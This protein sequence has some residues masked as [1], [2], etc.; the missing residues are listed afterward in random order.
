MARALSVAD[1]ERFN[2][3]VLPLEGAWYDC[4]GAIERSGTILIYGEPK[5][6]KTR[7]TLELCKYLTQFGKVAYNSMEEGL[8]LSMKNALIDLNM[9]AVAKNFTLLNREPIRE[10]KQRLRKQKS[11]D[12]VVIDSLQY[13]GLK[14]NE[15]K[16]L[17]DGFNKKL[18]ILVSHAEGKE[19]KGQIAQAIK[20]DANAFVYIQGY[21]AFPVSRYGGGK[22][23]IIWHEGAIKYWGEKQ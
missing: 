4:L 21:K 20:Y 5:N 16:V 2:P 6:G 7:F 8:T 23:Y 14:Y 9:R 15:Y 19:P 12:I 17:R 10:L 3:V 13:S 1:V 18:F 11:P 22:P